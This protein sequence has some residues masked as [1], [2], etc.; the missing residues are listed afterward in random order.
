MYCVLTLF[1]VA[2]V[3][4]VLVIRTRLQMNSANYVKTELDRRRLMRYFVITPVFTVLY[5]LLC[6]ILQIEFDG[7]T[8]TY[9]Y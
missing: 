1:T 6:V 2:T 8:G 5:V 7:I 9:L 3:S 4:S